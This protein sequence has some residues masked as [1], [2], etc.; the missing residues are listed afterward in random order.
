MASQRS[1]HWSLRSASWTI[2]PRTRSMR[3]PSCSRFSHSSWNSASGTS[4][5]SGATAL[6]AARLA[7]WS[8]GSGPRVARLTFLRFFGDSAADPSGALL[9]ASLRGARTA[10]W[11]ARS[12]RCRAVLPSTSTSM[13]TASRARSS[14]APSSLFVAAQRCSAVQRRAPGDALMS[15]P[16][17]SMLATRSL[18]PSVAHTCRHVLASSRQARAESSSP[19]FCERDELR[20]A[21]LGSA[22][23]S[24]SLATM[25]SSCMRHAWKSGERPSSSSVLTRPPFW[26]TAETVSTFPPRTA[27]NRA[28]RPAVSTTSTEAPVWSTSSA[29]LTWPPESACISAV[30]PA[31]SARAGFPLERSSRD[32]ASAWPFLAASMRGVVLCSVCPSTSAPLRSSHSM[33]LVSLRSAEKWRAATPLESWTLTFVP[34]LAKSLSISSLAPAKMAERKGVTPPASLRFGSASASRKRVMSAM[35]QRRQA[36]CRGLSLRA[37]GRSASTRPTSRSIRTTFS[38]PPCT[39]WCRMESPK[40]SKMASSQA[41]RPL[42]V[43]AFSAR[44]A[45][46]VLSSALRHAAMKSSTETSHGS[47]CS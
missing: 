18:C 39:A 6:S 20:P 28:L 26:M 17:S 44:K 34:A 7:A 35:S 21:R 30:Q 12:A 22:P 47:G 40:E 43:R 10:S 4:S 32:T 5:S 11:P 36:S 38:L 42:S 23:A 33:S 24:R 3:E 41:A 46:T 15:A 2:G 27:W 45:C 8:G 14:F 16:R 13:T 1:R 31:S 37:L 9:A 25:S 29:A 19:P